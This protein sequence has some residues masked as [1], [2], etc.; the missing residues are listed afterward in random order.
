MHQD[1]L[2][3]AHDGAYNNDLPDDDERSSPRDHESPDPVQKIL[4]DRQIG[5]H[6]YFEEGEHQGLSVKV[7]ANG[8]GQK[9][10]VFDCEWHHELHGCVL[11]LEKL[12]RVNWTR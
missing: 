7:I 8:K 1:K 4:A 3:L 11:N 6:G 5:D 9:Q 12:L 10:A 2:T